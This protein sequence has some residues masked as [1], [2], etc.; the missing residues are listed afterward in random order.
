MIESL[1]QGITT[2]YLL[3]QDYEQKGETLDAVLETVKHV[4]RAI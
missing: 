3:N 1:A 2:Q 4:I